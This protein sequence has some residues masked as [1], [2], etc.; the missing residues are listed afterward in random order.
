[1]PRRD[2]IHTILVIG[3]GYGSAGRLAS[4]DGLKAETGRI[5]RLRRVIVHALITG[6]GRGPIHDVVEVTDGILRTLDRP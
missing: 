6:K 4:R 1:M 2:D 3:C 5:H